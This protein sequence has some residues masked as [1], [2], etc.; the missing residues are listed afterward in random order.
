MSCSNRRSSISVSCCSREQLLDVARR[1]R[2]E[3]IAWRFGSHGN[4]EICHPD[5]GTL[6]RQSEEVTDLSP[7][8][9]LL[10]KDPVKE[11]STLNPLF[12]TY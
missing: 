2:L 9:I 3:Q 4:L 6:V 1:Y 10:R 12:T 7:G 5:L 11:T 8:R